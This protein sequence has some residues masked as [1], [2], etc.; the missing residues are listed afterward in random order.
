M[1]PTHDLSTSAGLHSSSLLGPL[2]SMLQPLPQPQLH[3]PAPSPPPSQLLPPPQPPPPPLPGRRSS[4]G[5]LPPDLHPLSIHSSFAPTSTA[6]PHPTS[7]FAEPSAAAAAAAPGDRFSTQP[8]PSSSSQSMVGASGQL[9]TLDRLRSSTQLPLPPSGMDA[10][11]V[12][13]LSILNSVHS[14]SRNTPGSSSGQQHV[15]LPTH[16]SAATTVN[17]LGSRAH[18]CRPSVD[19]QAFLP[20]SAGLFDAPH[21]AGGRQTDR[22]GAHSNRPAAPSV[23]RDSAHG[24]GYTLPDAFRQLS[25]DV[26]Q[27]SQQQPSSA[28]AVQVRTQTWK[29]GECTLRN[30]C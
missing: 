25:V 9:R 17:S 5:L 18:A 8:P 26:Q 15:S 11:S 29:G 30:L 3:E 27:P 14:R 28:S 16:G 21:S 1:G 13:P 7:P 23:A 4:E 2:P 24:S 12:A 10:T 20:L 19:R 6:A 22:G